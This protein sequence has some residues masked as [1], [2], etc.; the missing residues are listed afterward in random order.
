[1]W[2]AANQDVDV[3]VDSVSVDVDADTDVNPDAVV[4]VDALGVVGES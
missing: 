2:E 4:E 1:L 3:D